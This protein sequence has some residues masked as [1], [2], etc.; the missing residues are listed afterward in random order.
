[1]S[2]LEFSF[3]YLDVFH[4]IEEM[5]NKLT[6]EF[7]EVLMLLKIFDANYYLNFDKG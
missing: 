3:K 7:Q 5:T 6:L 4:A 1:M 2:K